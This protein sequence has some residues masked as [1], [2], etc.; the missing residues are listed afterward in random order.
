MLT[1]GIAYPWG[2]YAFAVV[3]ASSA[4]A[5][6]TVGATAGRVVPHVGRG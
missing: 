3:A 5:S 4:A 1:A 6:T 2:F